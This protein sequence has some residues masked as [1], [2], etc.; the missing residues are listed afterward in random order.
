MNLFLVNF[1]IKV[2]I[3]L[4]FLLFCSGKNWIVEIDLFILIGIIS[5]ISVN[6]NEWNIIIIYTLLMIIVVQIN[7]SE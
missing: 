6:N 5:I 1:Y 4:F 3:E 2:R 7:Y